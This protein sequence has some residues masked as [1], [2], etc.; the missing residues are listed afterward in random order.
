MINE[1]NPIA[2][3]ITKIQ[4]HWAQEVTPFPDIK[5]IRILIDEQES[6]LYEGFLKLESSANG[7]LPEFFVA[8]LTPFSSKR[9]YS[10]DLIN[11][12]LDAFERDKDVFDQ[13]ASQGR[14]L[15]WDHRKYREEQMNEAVNADVLLLQMLS[16]FQSALG[17]PN[18]H[19]TVALFHYSIG[20]ISE[21]RDWVKRIVD[22]NI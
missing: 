8:L 18:Q 3:L 6:R 12:W 16:T 19:L 15:T 20:S 5:L 22:L 17:V 14:R 4:Q 7:K 13:V 9:T 10:R 11:A 21:F 1:H 2:Q